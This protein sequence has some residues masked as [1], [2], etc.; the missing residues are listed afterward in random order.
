M[1]AVGSELENFLWLLVI[2]VAG[3][4]EVHTCVG[5]TFMQ[6]IMLTTEC[7]ACDCVS[8]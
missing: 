1:F 5:E 2:I 7:R 6:I 4:A 3:V 8:H